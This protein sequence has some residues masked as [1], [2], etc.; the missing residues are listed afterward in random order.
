LR[1]YAKTAPDA[2]LDFVKKTRL[3]PLTK[4]EALKIVGKD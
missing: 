3:A 2:V 1:Q 4:R